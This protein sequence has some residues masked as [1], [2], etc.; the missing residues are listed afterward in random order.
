VIDLVR[1][2]YDEMADRFGAWRAGITGSPELEWV[3][4]LLARLPPNPD[5]LELGCGQAVEPTRLF[6]ERGRLVGIDI[7]SE[8][9]RRARETCPAGEFNLEDMTTV[10]FEAGSFDGVVSLY[11]FNHIPRTDLPP[12]LERI[13]GWLRPG[14]YLLATFGCSGAEGVE[15]DWLGVPMFFASYTPPENRAFVERAGLRVE[16]DEVVSILEPEPDPGVAR[17]QWIMA[18]TT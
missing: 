1:D 14:G 6:A 3:D 2:G 4:A 15:N 10:V 13:A 12:L 5:V 7:S 11:A 9:V 17:F 8:Q 16:R 18:R